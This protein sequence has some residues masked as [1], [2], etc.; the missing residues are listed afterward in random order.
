M[1]W[2]KGLLLVLSLLIGLPLLLVFLLSRS[3][4]DLRTFRWPG[5]ELLSIEQVTHGSIHRF[6]PPPFIGGLKKV[7]SSLPILPSIEHYATSDSLVLW[8]TLEDTEQ[9]FMIPL[10]NVVKVVARDSH[11]SRYISS[12][13][14]TRD[15]KHWRTR[16]SWGGTQTPPPT[17]K[18]FISTVTLQ[19][20]PKG[21]DSFEVDLLD[22][23]GNVVQ[24]MEIQNPNITQPS[25]WEWSPL[26]VEITHDDLI[27][28]FTAFTNT[29]AI[30]HIG[31][32]YG[33]IPQYKP[34]FEY[35]TRD[36]K[37]A[38]YWL[39]DSGSAMDTF[40][41]AVSLSGSD[42]GNL[43]LRSK[44]WKITYD[45]YRQ[46]ESPFPPD[47]VWELTVEMPEEGKSKTLELE[48]Q[49]M[50]VPV[51]ILNITGPKT[52][53][54]FK[55]GELESAEP[56]QGANGASLSSSSTY[57]G[58]KFVSTVT[59]TSEAS[60]LGVHFPEDYHKYRI[61]LLAK[62]KN[63]DYVRLSSNSRS[64]H[65][66]FMSLQAEPTESSVD[67][68]VI[69]Q[70]VFQKSFIVE[71]SITPPVHQFTKAEKI[72]AR[73]NDVPPRAVD[74]SD[75]YTQRLDQ[76]AHLI[77]RI[78]TRS[79]GASFNYYS[80]ETGVHRINGQDWDLR[81]AVL[82]TGKCLFNLYLQYP[83]KIESI[84]ISSKASKVHFLHG[85]LWPGHE[86]QEIGNYQVHY[87]NGTTYT[88]PLIYDKNI[89]NVW[90]QPGETTVSEIEQAT[91]VKLPAKE[92]RKGSAANYSYHFTWNNP[93][94]ELTIEHIAVQSNR[95][96]S[97]PLLLGITLE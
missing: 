87:N 76:H 21:E 2:I 60:Y 59:Y 26:P 64:Q 41:N 74:L 69:V 55:D 29:W 68:K 86:G 49:L 53:A 33:E 12:E 9:G 15:E 50:G 84:P 45:F 66:H 61:Q 8:L 54:V 85:C 71:P 42:A 44:T 14:E 57:V 90:D 91:L 67:L 77:G 36:N 48:K 62:N 96:D 97:A 46:A 28:R 80:V 82:M 70:P 13:I 10:T 72:P 6:G 51:K 18:W 27:I 94:P 43:S 17:S 79:Y 5:G 31:Q 95:K 40:G 3:S 75:H 73:P 58:G 1:K 78:G 83:E 4:S 16:P 93:N 89:A 19:Q 11:G 24:T 56:A 47:Q 88:I 30:R 37:T 38:P 34:H 20:Y 39:S 52:K 65:H 81:G 7:L 25:E 22:P 32:D 35:L 23:Y 63:G 92:E